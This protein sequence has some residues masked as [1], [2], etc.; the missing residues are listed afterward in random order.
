VFLFRLP[1]AALV[2][3]DQPD[4]DVLFSRTIVVVDHV[5]VGEPYT[6]AGVENEPHE[7]I[8][9]ETYQEQGDRVAFRDGGSLGTLTLAIEG[10]EEVEVEVAGKTIKCQ[11]VEST[12]KIADETSMN[13]LWWSD[14]VPGG[15]VK[16]VT[17]KKQGDKVFF[18]RTTTLL[19]FK[20]GE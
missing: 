20:T 7:R 6:F 5:G 19:N 2:L 13:K 10:E 3:Q 11:W 15:T 4:V 17:T 14:S 8:V 12:I 16:Q 18:V 9:G 1:P